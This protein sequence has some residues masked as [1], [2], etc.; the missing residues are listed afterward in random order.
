MSVPPSF[1]PRP[2]EPNDYAAWSPSAPQTRPDAGGAWQPRRPDVPGEP[3]PRQWGDVP[4]TPPR[5]GRPSA[6]PTVHSGTAVVEG[7]VR[8]TQIRSE[9]RGENQSEAIWS[10][11]LERYDAA[12]NR[13]VLV[14]V[15]MRGLTF[16]G[17]L[18]DGDWVRARGRMK[19]GTLHVTRLENLT[20]GACVRAKGISKPVLILAYVMMAAIAAFVAWGFYTLFF[21]APTPPA[22]FPNGW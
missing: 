5:D 12:G 6:P 3:P 21:D 8:G 18:N 14:P 9:N 16:E 17:S 4:E 1:A 19:S 2:S 15:E 7:Q 11:R 22:D 20:T 10:F 13:A